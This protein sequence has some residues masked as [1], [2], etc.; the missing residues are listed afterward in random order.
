MAEWKC[1]HPA[2]AVVTEEERKP[3]PTNSYV[4]YTFDTY[5]LWL[6]ITM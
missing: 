2:M 6:E 5:A 1:R 3:M 4:P